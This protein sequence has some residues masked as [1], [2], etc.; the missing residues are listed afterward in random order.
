MPAG[1]VSDQPTLQF[2]HRYEKEDLSKEQFEQLYL[3]SS[4]RQ[5]NDIN[6]FVRFSELLS[7]EL[8]IEVCDCM[9]DWFCDRE[10]WKT[11]E[12]TDHYVSAMMSD[13]RLIVERAG[14]FELAQGRKRYSMELGP[15]KI[16]EKWAERRVKELVSRDVIVAFLFAKRACKHLLGEA[17]T[18]GILR[19]AVREEFLGNTEA[20]WEGVKG[21]RIHLSWVLDTL[22]A[23]EDYEGIRSQVTERVVG[24]LKNECAVEFAE[25]VIISLVH[26]QFPAGQPDRVE[27][28]EFSV[29]KDENE[30]T[31]DM[32]VLLPVVAG[33]RGRELEDAVA[34]KAFD[35]LM[36]AYSEELKGLEGESGGDSQEEGDVTC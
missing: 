13:V 3:S 36:K 22:T 5:T 26:Y 18:N 35:V 28:Y 2:I 9:L 23:G 6:T 33:L 14:Q 32:D 24:R 19:T 1:E 12:S 7:E 8:A 4:E 31:Y 16:M 30:K 27:E 15:A 34:R 17:K 10:H 11:W 29:K 25:S 20:I 21:G